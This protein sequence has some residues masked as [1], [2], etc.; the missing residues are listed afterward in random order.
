MVIVLLSKCH[1]IKIL[2]ENEIRTKIRMDGI[3][4]IDHTTIK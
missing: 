4:Y 3:I 2:Q 1:L